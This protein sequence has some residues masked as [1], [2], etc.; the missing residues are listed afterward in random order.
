MIVT[1]AE[2][3]PGIDT[4]RERAGT[5]PPRRFGLNLRDIALLLVDR[6]R[7]GT[8]DLAEGLTQAEVGSA[9]CLADK[10]QP[11]GI[12]FVVEVRDALQEGLGLIVFGN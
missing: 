10:V 3:R 4:R 9:C 11:A 12:R 6:E 7:I 5:P 2:D 8:P 1:G